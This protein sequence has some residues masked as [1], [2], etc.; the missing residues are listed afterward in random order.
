MSESSESDTLA[1]VKVGV[2]KLTALVPL[3]PI[4]PKSVGPETSGTYTTRPIKAKYKDGIV[5]ARDTDYY[6]PAQLYPSGGP[7]NLA[8]IA[9]AN[10]KEEL[11]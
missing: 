7:G 1:A 5:M 2:G 4:S 3:L 8:P 9:S 10:A 6:N 11:G